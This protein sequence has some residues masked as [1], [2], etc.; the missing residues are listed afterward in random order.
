MSKAIYKNKT[1]PIV[2]SAM[3][4]AL[5]VG[6]K[7]ALVTLP[8]IEVVTLLIAL[9]AYVWGVKIALFATNVFVLCEMAIWG[10]NTWVISYFIHFNIVA[11]SFGLISLFKLKGTRQIIVT[12]TTAVLLTAMFGILTTVVDTLIGFS[13]GFYIVATDFAKRFAVMYAAG[14]Y[15]FI[16]H[17]AC[18]LI[19][20]AVGFVPLVKIN[21]RTRQKLLIDAPGR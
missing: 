13:G 14:I 7:Q 11:V 6:G 5:L 4:A 10:I 18:N 20:F 1:V 15:F 2:I 19:L 16:L 3:F 12:T 21:Q 9:C 8:N 17:I